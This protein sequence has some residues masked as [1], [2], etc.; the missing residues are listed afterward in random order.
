MPRGQACLYA[1]LANGHLLARSDFLQLWKFEGGLFLMD[2][3]CRKRHVLEYW[4]LYRHLSQSSRKL[5]PKLIFSCTLLCSNIYCFPCCSSRGGFE[6]PIVI[7]LAL[8]NWST[9]RYPH[10]FS[11][12]PPESSTQKCRQHSNWTLPG[13]RLCARL[14][15]IVLS[16]NYTSNSAYHARRTSCYTLNCQR[17]GHL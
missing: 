2:C 9:V 17:C 13:K 15:A 8:S 6:R 10:F 16:S 1:A 11:A 5:L 12:T 3:S 4:H 7:S 14:S